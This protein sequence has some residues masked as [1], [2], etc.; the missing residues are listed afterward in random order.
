MAREE[1]ILAIVRDNWERLAKEYGLTR[2]QI[3]NMR[4]AF[5]VDLGIKR[6]PK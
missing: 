5:N 1:E 2:S 4:S 3:E 6:G